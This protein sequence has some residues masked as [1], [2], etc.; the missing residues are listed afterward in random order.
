MAADNNPD[1][2]STAAAAVVADNFD[3][4][5][6]LVNHLHPSTAGYNYIAVDID[7]SAV[8]TDWDQSASDTSTLLFAQVYTS[9]YIVFE[10]F[11][12]NQIRQNHNLKLH[13]YAEILTRRF[14]FRRPRDKRR[15]PDKFWRW[16]T[17]RAG[18]VA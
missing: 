7:S 5:F 11:W 18:V 16:I 9:V 1:S 14:L 2:Q 10:V 15:Y 17:I 3:K 6:E 8:G 13:L 12:N 4:Y